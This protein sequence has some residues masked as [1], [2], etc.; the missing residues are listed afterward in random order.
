MKKVAITPVRTARIFGL[1]LAA[2]CIGFALTRLSMRATSSSSGGAYKVPKTTPTTP[3]VHRNIV[4]TVFWVGEPASKDNNFISNTA[5][6]WD[7]HWQA[8]Y[9][10]IDDPHARSA[11][12]PAAFTPKENP[13]YFA[14]PYTDFDPDNTRKNSAVGCLPYAPDLSARYS[15]CKNIWIAIRHNGITAYAQWEDAGPTETDDVT[16]VFG[17][18]SPKNTF[19]A[20]AGLDVSPAVRDYLKLRDVDHTDWAFVNAA[21]VPDGPWKMRVTTSRGDSLY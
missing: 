4:T 16:Y 7:E 19:G 11:Y 2:G 17:T 20:R 14:L 6:A 10:G 13:F 18:A 1:L 5:S 9:G 12:F 15:W 8:H 3:L 21:N